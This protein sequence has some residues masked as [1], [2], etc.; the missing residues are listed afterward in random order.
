MPTIGTV[1]DDEMLTPIQEE[2]ALTLKI[3][4]SHL[5]WYKW[6]ILIAILLWLGSVALFQLV[7]FVIEEIWGSWGFLQDKLCGC[8]DPDTHWAYFAKYFVVNGIAWLVVL[9]VLETMTTY[10]RYLMA[11]KAEATPR[12]TGARERLHS[13]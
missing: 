7:L 6:V 12:E 9:I 4:L 5:P 13:S 11:T 8:A 10:W 3:R 1:T 2:T